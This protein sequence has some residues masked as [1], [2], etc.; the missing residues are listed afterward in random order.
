ML[1]AD[2]SCGSHPGGQALFQKQRSAE[3]D[4]NRLLGSIQDAVTRRVK[5]SS[6]YS[7]CSSAK[8]TPF[9]WEGWYMADMAGDMAGGW[10][11]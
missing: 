5:G 4:Q 7:G 8:K 6:G 10:W 2:G 11:L 9:C 3:Q 1:E